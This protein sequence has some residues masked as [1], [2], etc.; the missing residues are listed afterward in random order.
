MYELCDE[1]A[2]TIARDAILSITFKLYFQDIKARLK[3]LNVVI[4]TRGILIN[5]G[6]AYS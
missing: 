3:Y 4:A 2:K 5:L 1:M 6:L